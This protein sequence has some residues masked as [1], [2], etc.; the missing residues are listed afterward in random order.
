MKLGNFSISLAVKDCIFR[1]KTNTHS[2]AKRTVIPIENE[3]PFRSK[4][5][6]VA[7]PSIELSDAG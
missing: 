6:S 5:N 4:T 2:D 7:R 1:R 3:H